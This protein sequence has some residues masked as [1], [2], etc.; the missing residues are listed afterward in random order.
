MGKNRVG[1]VGAFSIRVASRENGILDGTSCR[2]SPGLF[3]KKWVDLSEPIHVPYAI[4]SAVALFL[5]WLCT[6]TG[7]IDSS[8][9]ARYEVIPRILLYICRSGVFISC[10]K[11]LKVTSRCRTTVTLA[12]MALLDF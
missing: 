4:S 2:W 7:G 11:E 8:L 1:D 10:A 5:V 3:R 6:S 9:G 12:T